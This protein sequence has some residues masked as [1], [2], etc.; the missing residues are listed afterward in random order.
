MAETKKYTV[1]HPV[2]HDGKLYQRGKEIK[3]GEEDATRLLDR[4]VIA[5]GAPTVVEVV[6]GP[7]TAETLA[8][9]NK[10]NKMTIPELV[11]YAQTTYGLDLPS[12][13]KKEAL[14]TAIHERYVAAFV[15]AAV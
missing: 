15:P 6:S 7:S 8:S 14:V 12:D 10:L 5:T 13:D 9:L 11:A 3:L 2:R 1:V 4:G